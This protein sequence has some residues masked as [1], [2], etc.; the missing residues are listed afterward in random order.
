VPQFFF[1]LFSSRPRPLPQRIL[2]FDGICNVCNFFVNT[3]M[4]FDPERR[5][6]FASRDS[7]IG[8]KLFQLYNIPTTL[9]SMILIENAQ[10][11]VKNINNLPS[12]PPANSRAYIK[13]TAAIKIVAGFSPFL[14]WFIFGFILP[15]F[16]R[17]FLYEIFAQHRYKLFGKN[18]QACRIL[19]KDIK[20]QFLEFSTVKSGKDK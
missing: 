19:T 7:A 16:L 3:T 20:Q 12:Q 9:D 14:G 4:D 8:Q 6:F 17:D 10:E 1:I 2:L 15:Q 13:S 18:E 11:I 5:Y